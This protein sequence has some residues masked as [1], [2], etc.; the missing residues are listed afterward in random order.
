MDYCRVSLRYNATAVNARTRFTSVLQIT[1][2]SHYCKKII[3]NC[4]YLKA[5]SKNLSRRLRYTS[6]LKPYKR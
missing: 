2:Q 5:M 4:L 6:S 3:L 1:Y